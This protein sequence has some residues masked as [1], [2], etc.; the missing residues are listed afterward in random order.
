[1]S[2]MHLAAITVYITG[3]NFASGLMHAATRRRGARRQPDLG[4]NVE[5]GQAGLTRRRRGA[6]CGRG[7]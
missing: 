4:D 5:R 3:E 7:D 1:M 2:S 6:R